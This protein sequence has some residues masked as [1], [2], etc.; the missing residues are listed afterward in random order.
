MKKGLLTIGS[1][2]GSIAITIYLL[3][4]VNGTITEAFADPNKEIVLR[5]QN[6][7]QEGTSSDKEETEE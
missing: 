6:T 7:N 3:G 5:D 4:F 2:I 1:T